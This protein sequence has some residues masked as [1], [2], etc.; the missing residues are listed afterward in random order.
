MI[1]HVALSMFLGNYICVVI[2]VIEDKTASITTYQVIG[3]I[4]LS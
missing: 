4:A 1:T 2:V 3:L